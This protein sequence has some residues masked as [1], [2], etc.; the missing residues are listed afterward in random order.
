MKK[1]NAKD[2]HLVISYLLKNSLFNFW[3]WFGAIAGAV[4]FYLSS[5][6]E[7]CLFGGCF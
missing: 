3:F 5:N 1:S 7:I 6:T 2:K 4:A